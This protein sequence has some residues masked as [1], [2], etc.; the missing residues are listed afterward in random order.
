MAWTDAETETLLAEY[1]A[2][3]THRE[4][5]RML[6]RSRQAV[7]YRLNSLGKVRGRSTRGDDVARFWGK[8]DR[9]G[10]GE[11]WRWIGPAFTHGYGMFSI[12]PRVVLASRYCFELTHR[13]LREGEVVMHSCD[14]PL[15]VNPAHLRAGSHAD[16]EADKVAKGRQARGER[17]GM[18]RLTIEQVREILA[19]YSGARGEQTTLAREYGVHPSTVHLIVHGKHWQGVVTE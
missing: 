10:P 18:A 7:G 6:G 17:H 11:C 1:E 8:V 12:W 14:V 4:I 16:N 9:R 15:C 13:P 3:R 19:R 5:A 2:G